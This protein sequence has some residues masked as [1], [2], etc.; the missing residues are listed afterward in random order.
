MRDTG[1]PS[2][3]MYPCNHLKI[4]FHHK[5]YSL[6]FPFA[7]VVWCEAPRCPS[8]RATTTLTLPW[9]RGPQATNWTVSCPVDFCSHLYCQDRLFL[10]C[11]T[12]VLS[13]CCVDLRSHLSTFSLVLV[14]TPTKSLKPKEP[15]LLVLTCLVAN[16]A[17]Q[18]SPTP[19][20]RTCV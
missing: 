9:T 14:L 3:L 15:V 2:H 12:C 10:F 18:L 19:A 1:L 20:Q 7:P 16:W 11:W 13:C 4:T 17:A 8:S 6:P 5:T